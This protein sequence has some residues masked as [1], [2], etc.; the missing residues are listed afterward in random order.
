MINAKHVAL[1]RQYIKL[2]DSSIYDDGSI[3]NIQTAGEWVMFEEVSECGNYRT[4][5]QIPL[6]DILAELW[7]EIK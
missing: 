3:E 5:F 2:T 6:F 7:S 4:S 1:L